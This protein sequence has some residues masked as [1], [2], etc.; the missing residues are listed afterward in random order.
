[1]LG[2]LQIPSGSGILVRKLISY[3]IIKRIFKNMVIVV[4]YLK[5]IFYINMYEQ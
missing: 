2:S 4:F 3:D 5:I 1:M